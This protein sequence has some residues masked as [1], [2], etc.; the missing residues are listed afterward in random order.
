M[1]MQAY[2]P[3]YPPKM[4]NHLSSFYRPDLSNSNT[5]EDNCTPKKM[6]VLFSGTGKAE[7]NMGMAEIPPLC[8]F[9]LKIPYN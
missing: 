6:R 5:N 3:Q 7:R 1:E 9:E 8:P 2:I 4:V